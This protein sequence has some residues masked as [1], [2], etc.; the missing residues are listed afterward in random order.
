MRDLV[1]HR[2]DQQPERNA[3]PFLGLVIRPTGAVAL[4]R[5]AGFHAGAVDGLGDGALGLQVPFLDHGLGLDHGNPFDRPVAVGDLGRLGADDD[6][7]QITV[8]LHVQRLAFHF[9]SQHGGQL[10]GVL[11]LVARGGII[12]CKGAVVDLVEREGDA[13]AILGDQVEAAVRIQAASRGG[14]VF[15]GHA[16]ERNRRG[17]LAC[18]EFRLF[19]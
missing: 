5:A 8:L 10:D 15:Q 9:I 7:T 19:G 16:L 12:S 13:V 14:Q 11:E 2:A 3:H 6:Q 1:I 4:R 18:L 17:D